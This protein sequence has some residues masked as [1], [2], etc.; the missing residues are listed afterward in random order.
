VPPFKKG[1]RQT[2]QMMKQPG[3][4]MKAQRVL[5]N[6]NNERSGRRRRNLDQEEEPE[7]Q[8]KYEK[9]IDVPSGDDLVDRELHVEGRGEG[10][11][12]DDHR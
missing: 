2:H 3:A 10:K 6:Q 7:P 5:Q 8:P 12:L 11:N 4:N 1:E 9:E